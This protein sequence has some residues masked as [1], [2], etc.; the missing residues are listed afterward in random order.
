MGQR[1]LMDSNAVIDFTAKIIPQNGQ[2]F[3]SQFIDEEFLIPSIVKIEVLGF[4][5]SSSEKTQELTEL[6]I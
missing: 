4:N 3:I 1:F 5:E 6:L 2:E